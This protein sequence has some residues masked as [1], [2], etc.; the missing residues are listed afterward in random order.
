MKD[1]F[2]Q[3]RKLLLKSE[4][5]KI[6]NITKEINELK[7]Q[8]QKDIVIDNL[9]EIITNILLKS[10]EKNQQQLYSTLNPIISKGVK[11]EINVNNS[12]LKEVLFP[13][14]SSSIQEQVH[15][16]KDTI[17][18]ALYPIMGNMISKYVS[19]AVSDMVYD[20]NNTIQSSLSFERTIRKIK[21]KLYGVS[22]AQL[23]MQET[24]FV[25]INTIF[26]I[27]KE[28]GL[29]ITDLHREDESKIEEVEMVAS[30]LSAIRSFVN[31]WISSHNTMSEISEIEYGNS[32]ISIESAGSCYL[33]I[34]TDGKKSLKDKPSKVLSK[35]VNKYSKELASY[36]GDTTQLDITDIKD[37]L[38]KLFSKEE[39]KNKKSFPV[40]SLSLIFL[41]LFS[42]GYI[43]GSKIYKE[44]QITEKENNIKEILDKNKIHIYDLDIKT[45]DNGDIIMNGIVSSIEDK[46]KSKFLLLKYKVINNL[47]SIDDNFYKNY[48]K[49]Y[50]DKI[51]N[52][53]NKQYNSN[54]V[55][56]FNKKS[57]AIMGTIIDE[58][59]KDDVQNRINQLFDEFEVFFHIKTLPIFNDRIYFKIGSY[60]LEKEYN[61]TIDN[62]ANI[63]K[64]YHYPITIT[65]YSD[66]IGKD[67]VNKNISF[68]RA[69]SIRD[70]LIK[71]GIPKEDMMINFSSL[72]PDNI[73][74]INSK[75]SRYLSRCVIF[76]WEINKY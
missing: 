36:D 14:I 26:L 55:Y 19:T 2:S 8:Q 13:I 73:D 54:L 27:H 47:T 50:L 11:E 75:K 40:F 38:S 39:R 43:Y 6:D 34:V 18:D 24:N 46:D 22:E 20:I 57:I 37:E 62:I 66:G 49:I 71:R 7:T 31:D 68:K 48:T 76:N 21:A 44:K 35:I 74:N 15:N 3:L 9:S 51:I 42:F 1:D 17:V 56:R 32:S 45:L 12:D 60:T 52:F 41:I 65:G 58:D 70:E 67:S 5:D 16:Q 69:V 4:I 59:A 28:S 29:L 53:I 72:P 25:K 10:M 30:M 61:I 63:I 23:L 33:A 64:K